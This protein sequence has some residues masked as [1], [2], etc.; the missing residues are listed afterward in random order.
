MM[1]I[2]H[3]LIW[4]PEEYQFTFFTSVRISSANYAITWRRIDCPK[5]S[6]SRRFWMLWIRKIAWNREQTLEKSNTKNNPTP[7]NPR[8]HLLRYNLI[9]LVLIERE[10]D[11]I[12]ISIQFAL[13]IKTTFFVLNCFATI[14]RIKFQMLP[15]KEKKYCNEQGSS[16]IYP[17]I[18][19]NIHYY[20]INPIPIPQHSIKFQ[21]RGK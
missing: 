4:H 15:N 16:Q 11:Q 19:N 5:I 12:N 1:D 21:A 6:T 13:E 10:N 18:R 17:F 14:K 8:Q 2:L 3:H 7:T 20:H 9:T